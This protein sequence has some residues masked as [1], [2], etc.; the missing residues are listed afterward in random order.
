MGDWS[1][2]AD[3][4]AAGSPEQVLRAHSY[5]G[6]RGGAGGPV[7]RQTLPR[8][9]SAPA[10]TPPRDGMPWSRW[11]SGWAARFGR[12]HSAGAPGSR[13]TTRCSPAICRGCAAGCRTRSAAMTS[14]WRSARARSAHTCSTSRS[15]SCRR[16]PGLPCSP[17]SRLRRCAAR[18]ISRW[19]RRSPPPARPWPSS[20]GRAS[21]AASSAQSPAPARSA[22]RG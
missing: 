18:A 17:T 6:G 9:W 21:A 7:K 13:R 12:R 1:Q 14:C 10:L 11:R 19:W 3:E 22:R 20:Y 2:P 8:W 4:L 5:S 16:E 15:R